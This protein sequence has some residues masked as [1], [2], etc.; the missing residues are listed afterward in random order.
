MLA[1]CHGRFTGP[2]QAI[3][4]PDFRTIQ[5]PGQPPVCKWAKTEEEEEERQGENRDNATGSIQCSPLPPRKCLEM[6]CVTLGAGPVRQSS[7]HLPW[8]ERIARDTPEGAGGGVDAAGAA[9][10]Q[11][12]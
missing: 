6:Q 8:K 3:L 10:Q 4:G 5:G 9:M 2:R 11:V 12:L 1:L 7:R